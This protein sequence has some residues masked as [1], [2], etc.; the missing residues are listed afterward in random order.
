MLDLRLNRVSVTMPEDS[1][2]QQGAA[3]NPVNPSPEIWVLDLRADPPVW[4]LLST[5][6]SP[7]GRRNG[8]VVWDE[9]SSRMY[10]FGGTADAATTSPGLFV[11]D[12]RPG[13]ERWLELPLANP[14]D[15]RSSGTGFHDGER[16]YFGF[17]N[18]AALYRDW[19][20][21]GY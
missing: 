10:V 19:A 17:G 16:A 12:A 9:V 4:S 18:G 15:F 20:V 11:L 8:S 3:G 2:A 21:L 6:F 13:L 14:P 7:P 5:A 1:G